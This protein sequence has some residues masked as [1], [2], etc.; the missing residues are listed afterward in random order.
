MKA[1]ASLRRE[2]VRVAEE[3]RAVLSLADL[4]ERLRAYKA[5]LAYSYCF[6]TWASLM[7][8]FPLAFTA[9]MFSPWLPAVSEIWHVLLVA[10]LGTGM[11]LAFALTYYVPARLGVADL[12]DARWASAAW[13]LSFALPYTI[14]YGLLAAIGAWSYAPVAW[15]PAGGVAFLSVGLTVERAL[16]RRRFLPARPF[17]LAGT[18][19]LLAS[20]PVLY[21]AS[22]PVPCEYRLLPPG[23]PTTAWSWEAGPLSAM[24]LAGALSLTIC[25]TAAIYT[26]LTAERV[27]FGHG[28][29]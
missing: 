6:I 26:L 29:R 19:A 17:L 8:G 28:A 16:V 21:L 13:S 5:S 27:V 14:A 9:L 4:A 22:L 23:A 1:S 7:V 2:V 20:A 3:M 10:T 25:F 24:L 11:A 12:L 18:S 15:L